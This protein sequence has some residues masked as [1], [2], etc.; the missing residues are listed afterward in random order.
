MMGVLSY[1]PL[2]FQSGVGEIFSSKQIDFSNDFSEWESIRERVVP[3]NGQQLGT[4][5]VIRYSVMLNPK[6]HC[7]E[8]YVIIDDGKKIWYT[9]QKTQNNSS[10][11]EP[12]RKINPDQ[13]KRFSE[14][15]AIPDRNKH[16]TIF[17]MGSVDNTIYTT[18]RIDD[19]SVGNGWS[20]VGNNNPGK[21]IDGSSVLSVLSVNYNKKNDGNL[22]LFG[23]FSDSETTPESG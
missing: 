18:K 22:E 23:V 4:G 10:Q 9:R 6:N 14:I 2:I 19:T 15:T 20:Q 13:D 12:W 17:A 3:G 7:I 1:L 11:W 5:A 16:I 21:L 8:I